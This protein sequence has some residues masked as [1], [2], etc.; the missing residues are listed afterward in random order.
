MEAGAPGAP[1]DPAVLRVVEEQKSKLDPVTV[2]NQNMV[3]TL[4]QDQTQPVLAVTQI[5]VQL[6]EAGVP[7][8]PMD[9]AVLH[10]VE[11][12]KSKI[13]HAIVQSL[14]MVVKPAQDLP[15]QVLAATQIYVQ[16]MEAGAPGAPMDP[17][18]LRVAE[19]QKSKL[20]PVTIHS[21]NMVVRLAQD[22]KM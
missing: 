20:D 7:G 4:V 9:P 17:A 5:H 22:Q 10:V 3:V 2:H 11:E 6:M 1:M 12:P 19:E 21:H 14:S 15:H 8:A 18:V 16:L 13:D